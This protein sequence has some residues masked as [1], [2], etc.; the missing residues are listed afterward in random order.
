MLP[1]ASATVQLSGGQGSCFPWGRRAEK[2]TGV[3]FRLAA[4]SRGS[5]GVAIRVHIPAKWPCLQ[6]RVRPLT[7]GCSDLLG[8]CSLLRPWQLRF[9]H[10]IQRQEIEADTQAERVADT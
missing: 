5:S 3:T 9:L 1:V 6:K 7:E 10:H 2:Y 8:T 4:S